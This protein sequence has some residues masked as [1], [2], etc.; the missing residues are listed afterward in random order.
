MINTIYLHIGTPKTGTSSIQQ[1]LKDFDDRKTLYMTPLNKAITPTNHNPLVTTFE[2][3]DD[4][5]KI[6][7]GLNDEGSLDAEKLS[8]I[9]ENCKLTLANNILK[10]GYENLIISAEAFCILSTEGINNFFKFIRNLN[11]DITVKLICYL[12]EPKSF[13]ASEYQQRVKR[14]LSQEPFRIE[15]KM[16]LHYKGVGRFLPFIKTDE[17]YIREYSRSKLT[18]NCVVEDICKIINIK[19]KKVLST[20]SSLSLEVLKLLH[21]LNGLKITYGNKNLIRA[22]HMF[23]NSLQEAY[24][25][26]ESK[27]DREVFAGVYRNSEILYCKNFFNIDFTESISE[28]EGKIPHDFLDDLSEIDQAPLDKIINEHKI[29][30]S[31]QAPLEK[32]VI[33]IYEKFSQI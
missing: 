29:D 14:H 30:I 28:K 22:R 6:L 4:H 27:I 10:P 23:I 3:G 15:K 32:K 13:C 24:S 31:G 19:I 25:G 9:K 33:S 1:S 16:N 17:L 8:L 7:W 21:T 18:N 5:P 20:N 2:V 12:R 26:S 11:S